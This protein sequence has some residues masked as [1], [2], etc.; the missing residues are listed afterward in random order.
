M[1]RHDTDS[2]SRA[3][4][5]SRAAQVSPSS[6]HQFPPCQDDTWTRPTMSPT[7]TRCAPSPRRPWLAVRPHN[8][9]R[10]T[11]RL[12]PTVTRQHTPKRPTTPDDRR[13]TATGRRGAQR[14][15]RR[16]GRGPE[17]DR[18]RRRACHRRD[19]RARA[20]VPPHPRAERT[21]GA[22]RGAPGRA[23]P[24]GAIRQQPHRMQSRPVETWL[25]PV[26]GLKRDRSARVVGTGPCVR[27]EH[28][29][30]PL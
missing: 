22:G 7:S 18:G 14:R 17:L 29:S 26:R 19:R 11:T 24:H 15:R 25:R 1:F 3:D 10:P 4:H 20:G 30:W 12:P 27:A 16:A 8:D 21:G 6:A 13:G 9:S 5:T 23:G 2:P 28:S